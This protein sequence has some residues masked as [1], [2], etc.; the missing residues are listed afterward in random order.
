MAT[1]TRVD[2]IVERY[3][4][5]ES[6]LLNVLLDVQDEF[7]YLPK[8]V[9]QEVSEKTRVPL[10][11]I[12]GIATFYTAF[13]FVPRGRHTVTVCMG[14]T[15]YVRGSQRLLDEM[16][17]ELKIEQGQTTKDV[18]F[19]LESV[20]CVGCCAIAPVVTVDKRAHGK[21]EVDKLAGI[22]AKYE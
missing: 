10:A 6:A 17:R 19:S 7:R 15:C 11:R 2:E 18:R 4:G 3:R 16:K 1:A 8:E 5:E 21:V 13:S 14:T 22:L 9:L 12:F 20:R